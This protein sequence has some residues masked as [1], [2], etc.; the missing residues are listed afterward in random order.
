MNVLSVEDEILVSDIM[1]EVYEIGLSG[2]ERARYITMRVRGESRN[3]AEILAT[4]RYPG[5]KTDAIFNESKFSGQST[6]ECAARGTWLRQQA[7]AAGVSTTG[8][9]YCSGLASYPGDP[10]A[11]VDSRGDVL[12]IAREK[13]M[14]VHGYVEH[15]GH[16]TD[17]GGDIPIADD[18]I[19]NEVAD[20]LE[21]NPGAR[22]D[23][24]REHVYA[25]RTGAIDPNPL[26][27][28]D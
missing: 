9:W 7:E 4:R 10:T 1:N 24:V 25:L 21:E 11:W 19:D 13:N 26:L 5:L 15:Q 20:I 22:A 3:I 6:G 18:I 17:P 8:K 2:A 28:Q 14:T 16:E 23:D 27:V 12:R